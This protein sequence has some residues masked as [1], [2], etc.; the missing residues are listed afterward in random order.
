MQ[1]RSRTLGTLGSNLLSHFAAVN[2]SVFSIAEAKG[3]LPDRSNA[4]IAQLLS[5][6]VKAGWLIRLKRGCYLV[7]PLEA[8][9]PDSWSEDSFIIAAESTPPNSYSAADPATTGEYAISHWSALNYY[10]YTDQIPRTVFVSTPHRRTSTTREILDVPHRM[11]FVH[12]RKFF[13]NTTIWL[14]K[15]PVR[16]TDKEKTVVDCLDRPRLCGGIV[17]AASALSQ[18]IQDGIDLDEL[19]SYAARLGNRTVFKRLGFLAET[20]RLPVG[21]RIDE[22]QRSASGGYGLLDPT[23][24]NQGRYDG[25][26]RLIINVSE[27]DLSGDAA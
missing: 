5:R 20:L 8:K 11:V 14:D 10:G 6:L 21:S 27:D 24:A 2:K 18:A 1:Y 13:G 19:T 23:Q 16:I 22:W 7:V 3:A 9:S 17:E 4:A 15:K 12:P 25:R 26:W